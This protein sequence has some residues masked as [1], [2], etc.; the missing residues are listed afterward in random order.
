MNPK[1]SQ[2]AGRAMSTPTFMAL[3][4]EDRHAFVAAVEKAEDFDALDAKWKT[5]LKQAATEIKK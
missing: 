4:V 2:Q 5:L 1:L 3:S